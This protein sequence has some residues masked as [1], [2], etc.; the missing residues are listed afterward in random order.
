[1]IKKFIKKNIAIIIIAIFFLI[2]RYLK[3]LIFQTKQKINIIDNILSFSFSKNYG[4]AF[5]LKIFSPEIITVITGA[6]IALLFFYLIYLNKNKFP[7][8]IRLSLL[9]IILGALSNWLDR[10][11]YGYV[12]DYL[13]ILKLSVVNLADILISLGVIYLLFSTYKKNES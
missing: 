6:I 4:I 10:L 7:S 11:L 12:V 13:E 5:S 9:A 2:D 3:F 8:S 1:M